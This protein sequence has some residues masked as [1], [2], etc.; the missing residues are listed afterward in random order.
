MFTLA[1]PLCIGGG[2]DRSLHDGESSK[3]MTL[4]IENKENMQMNILLS[5]KV[6]I[7]TKTLS[8]TLGKKEL[9]MLD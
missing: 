4:E 7:M 1:F 5:S 9:M 3:K 8:V 2:G 6:K